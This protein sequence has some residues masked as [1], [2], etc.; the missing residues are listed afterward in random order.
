[1]SFDAGAIVARLGMDRSGFTGG[2]IKAQ[3]LTNLLGSNISTFLANPLLG[4]ANMAK[5]AFGAISKLVTGTAKLADEYA[6]LGKATGASVEFLSGMS[7]AA[8]LSGA[9]FNDFRQ[10]FE[11][12]IKSAGDAAEG[13]GESVSAFRALGVSV[14][15]ASG[16]LRPM[17]QIFLDV[18]QGLTGV[19]NS[20][21]RAALAQDI[22]GRGSAK[23]VPLLAE[24]RGG[25]EAMVAEAKRLGLTFD[26]ASAGSAERFNDSIV[27]LKGAFTGM[28]RQM[29]IPIFSSLV[30]ALEG[31]VTTLGGSLGPM[32]GQIGQMFAMVAPSIGEFV[33]ALGEALMPVMAAVFDIFQALMPILK[34]L[35]KYWGSMAKL[36]GAILAPALKMLVPIFKVISA[37]LSPIIDMISKVVDWIAGGLNWIAGLFGGGGGDTNVNVNVSPEDSADRVA[38]KVAPAIAGGV[39]HVQDR[40]ET[41]TMRRVQRMDYERGLALR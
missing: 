5:Q 14:T 11:R 20:S 21:Q 6:K 16:Q 22:F 27:R 41:T 34:T 31:L 15:D 4:V 28:A 23:L 26:E 25:I 35:F 38:K 9:S 13:T 32:L 18:A 8:E 2:I 40:V 1:M 19:E 36:I 30:P 17:Q 3:G 33:G 12:L 29:A 24:G 7:H 39:Q 37:V 10:G